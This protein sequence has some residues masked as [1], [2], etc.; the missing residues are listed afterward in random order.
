[1]TVKKPTA[2][3]PREDLQQKYHLDLAAAFVRG[4]IDHMTSEQLVI[5][6]RAA[7]LELQ[8]FRSVPVL[9]RVAKIIS[10]LKELQPKD[11]LDI[12]GGRGSSLVAM[13]DAFPGLEIHAIDNDEE[14]VLHLQAL[15]AGL[16]K[17]RLRATRMDATSLGYYNKEVFDGVTALEVLEHIAKPEDAIEEMLRVAKRFV[18][19]SVPSEP[20]SNPRHLHLL[21][22][23][24]LT[25][26]FD[27][28]GIRSLRIEQVPQ[29]T[30]ALAMKGR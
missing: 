21:T 29:H 1:V 22:P 3:K 23:R 12:G 17:S 2:P 25:S 15:A 16:R 9:P 30:I 20:D 14:R 18:L 7:G 6:G 13:L 11:L 28:V 26:I 5:A 8:R 19:V 27:A 4:S 24:N 10:I